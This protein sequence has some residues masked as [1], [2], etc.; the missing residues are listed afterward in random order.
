M[1]ASI[2]RQVTASL[3]AKVAESNTSKKPVALPSVPLKVVTKGT[4]KIASISHSSRFANF[5]DRCLYKH[6]I[7]SNKSDIDVLIQE[8][9]LLK[10]TIV[11]LGDKISNLENAI[12]TIKSESR[13]NSI[14]ESVI[15]TEHQ[16]KK[17]MQKERKWS[18][19]I[20][21]AGSCQDFKIS[22]EN[23]GSAN[24]GNKLKEKYKWEEN[25]E[26]WAVWL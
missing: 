2:C 10:A 19:R 25:Y 21:R 22:K 11:I 18:W 16:E 23:K 20:T 17:Q 26:L 9:K 8:V 12:D 24:K 3:A 7:F 5:W 1:Y 13:N 6:S 4:P 15:E 14:N